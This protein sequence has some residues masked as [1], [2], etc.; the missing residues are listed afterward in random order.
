[1]PKQ[2][3]VILSQEERDEL[4]KIIEKGK[5]A[6]QIKRAYILLSVDESVNGKQMT[7]QAVSRNYK[8]GISTIERLRKHFVTAGF[9][10]AV[11]DRV[12]AL[13]KTKKYIVTLTK[14]EREELINIVK[15]GKN[16]AQIKR[17]HI[18]LGADAAIAGKQM[19]DQAICQAYS[20]GLRTVERLRK[21]FV[22]AGL[23]IAL[24]GKPADGPKPRKID[25]DVEA[26]LIALNCREAPNGY[27]DWN[28][29][30]LADKMV[31]LEYIATISHESVRQT[32]K[33]N[34]LKPHK[35]L[36]WVIPP[37][38]NADFVCQME[39]VLH[40]YKRPYDPNHPVICLDETS[41][42][43]IS[44]TRLPIITNG[45][46]TLYDYEY[47]REGV[48]DI[49]MVCEPLAGKRYVTIRDSHNRL[50]WATV[51]AEI[52]TNKYAGA[53]KITLVQDNLSAHKPSAMYELFTPEQ[54]RCILDKIEFVYT[55]KHGSWLNI[56]E[57]ELS[58][59][60]RQCTNK[61]VPNKEILIEITNQ[62]ETHR[63]A[64]E[65]QVDWQFTT[66]QA[67]IKLKR[68][69]P[70]LYPSK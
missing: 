16:A 23:E 55:P 6:A 1:M 69:Y 17:C 26:H 47:K 32:L 58:V 48:S 35:R 68:L 54:A 42:Q 7:D 12:N 11:K 70:S 13:P 30:L 37:K 50:D 52:V 21:R 61:R 38:Q 51:V 14:N 20:V 49:Y 43:L 64:K 46:T 25:G 19:T 2:Y 27:K 59:L 3:T 56:A 5:N 40:V 33:K 28:L 62:W 8:V 45:G 34:E 15:K 57:I 63:N 41:K 18:L 24:K 65:V 31:E 36:C 10:I 22:T 67:R 4:S 53:N 66:A 60:S 29:R 44:E 9:E 39:Q